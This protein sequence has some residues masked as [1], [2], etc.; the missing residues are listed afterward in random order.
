MFM[1][2]ADILK[3]HNLKRSNCR[4]SIIEVIMTAG[5]AL[6][7]TE[8]REQLTGEYDRSTFY[9]SFKTLHQHNIIH[10]IVID[11][12]VVKYAL[13][14]GI[15]NKAEHAH[16]YC[17]ECQSVKCMDNIPVQNF[18]LPQGYTNNETVLLIKGTCCECIKENSN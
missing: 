11:N 17:Q 7:E 10:K 3:Y 14:K 9:R 4:E 6:S 18:D 1:K 5:K 8:I 13:D 15:S 16:F 12:K 2:P